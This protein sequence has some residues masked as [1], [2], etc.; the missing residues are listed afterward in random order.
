MGMDE[1]TLKVGGTSVWERRRGGSG[2]PQSP[3]AVCPSCNRQSA[4]FP[5]PHPS[6]HA[7]PPSLPPI[8]TPVYPSVR[9]SF[10]ACL[11]SC[12]SVYLFIC[13]GLLTHSSTP[14]QSSIQPLIH[15][16]RYPSMHLLTILHVSIYPK[17]LSIHDSILP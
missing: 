6:V 9:P 3:L 8:P 2:H 16:L 12:S 14:E 10:H 7:P 13:P 11:S 17:H 1:W 4:S 15:T 5:S